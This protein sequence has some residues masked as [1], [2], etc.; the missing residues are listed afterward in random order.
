MAPK[1]DL[2]VINR[3]RDEAA[4]KTNDLIHEYE[5][6]DDLYYEVEKSANGRT[7]RIGEN[8]TTIGIQLRDAGRDLKHAKANLMEHLLGHLE[9]IVVY[10]RRMYPPENATPNKRAQFKPGDKVQLSYVMTV[11]GSTWSEARAAW[12]VILTPE[13]GEDSRI[14]PE[15]GLVKVYPV[16]GPIDRMIESMQVLEA[17][18]E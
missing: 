5:R 13:S 9:D 15:N 11:A 4:Q 6:V 17:I 14:M 7:I 18:E 1:I 2:P 10:A 16:H 8:L 3:M 12:D